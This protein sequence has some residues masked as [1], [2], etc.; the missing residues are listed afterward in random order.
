MRNSIYY[1]FIALLLLNVSCSKNHTEEPAIDSVG[2]LATGF[3][4][5]I[6][7]SYIE[8]K[9]APEQ[10][11]F[12]IRVKNSTTNSYV[13]Q[14][15]RDRIA[16]ILEL[17][18][19]RYNIEADYPEIKDNAAFEQPHF[20]GVVEDVVIE[21][22]KITKLD[23][24][25]TSIQNMKVDVEFGQHIKDHFSEYSVTISNDKGALTFNKSTTESGYYTLS[26]LKAKFEGQRIE[27]NSSVVKDFGVIVTTI[28][29]AYHHKVVIDSKFAYT[30]KSLENNHTNNE[31]THNLFID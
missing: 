17:K 24:I 30:T 26:V 7:S 5:D 9:A 29:K 20:W 28:G 11:T 10:G 2:Y 22:D 23:K 4:N 31:F 14:S 25:E 21:K 13:Y 18:I 8:T 16:D 6:D 15:T 27:N 3:G 19:G 12:W 1:I